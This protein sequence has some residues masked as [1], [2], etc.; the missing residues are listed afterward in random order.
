MQQISTIIRHDF[1]R[2]QSVGVTVN[3]EAVTRMV[4]RVSFGGLGRDAC[5]PCRF[6]RLPAFPLS[7][8]P[9]I[10]SSRPVHLTVSG[11]AAELRLGTLGNV[12]NVGG[13]S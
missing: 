13:F 10:P 2:L 12:G 3:R 7:L 5:N 9:A 6:C 8:H 4:D 11:P 1:S